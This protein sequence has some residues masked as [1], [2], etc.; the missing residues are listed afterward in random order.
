MAVYPPSPMADQ[1]VSKPKEP[2]KP[3]HI[4]GESIVDR[5]LP[6]IKK[7]AIAVVVLAV[8]LTV[9][10]AFRWFQ[11]RKAIA[12]TGKLAEVL[13]VAERPVRPAGEAPD[14]KKPPSFGDSKERAGAVLDSIAKHDPATVAGA[15]RAG[16]LF[17]AGKF[18][19]AITDYKTC[20][21][22]TG[23]DGIVC[24]EGL[25]LAQ[26]AKATAEK[27]S[28]V[29]NA[30]FEEA[31]ATFK[32]MQPD[33]TGLRAGYAYY[34]QGRMLIALQKFPEAKAA[35]AKAKEIAKD[36]ADLTELIDKRLATMGAS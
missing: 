32:T 21:T 16:L 5:I 19:E 15:F 31:L 12:E 13:E 30:G 18:D 4:G 7:I 20:I 34:H 22:K 24:R 11:E 29:R 9:Y 25:G 14:P 17:D 3:V 33:D 26:E 36:S 35:F 1:D 6:H 8:V 10:F 28:K 27:D 2:P 23:L